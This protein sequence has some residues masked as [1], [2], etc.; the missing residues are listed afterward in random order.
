MQTLGLDEESRETVDTS[1]P[2]VG[3]WKR[4]FQQEPTKAQLRFDWIFGVVL[5]VICFYFDPVV[6]VNKIGPEPLL[7]QYKVEFYLFTYVSIMA[8]TAWLLWRE[9]LRLLSSI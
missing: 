1:A 6:F 9:R 7:G 5:P 8:M 4:Q 3:F 2:P